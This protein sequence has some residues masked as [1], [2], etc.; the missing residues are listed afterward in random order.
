MVYEKTYRW[1]LE[2]SEVEKEL[3]RN[4]SDYEFIRFAKYFEEIYTQEYYTSFVFC[5]DDWEESKSE[6]M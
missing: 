1:T 5:I 6:H 2:K 3:G 4:I